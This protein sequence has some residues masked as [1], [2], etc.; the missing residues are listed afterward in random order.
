MGGDGAIPTTL[1]ALLE[2]YTVKRI[3]GATR[4]ETNLEAL[5][6]SIIFNKQLIIASGQGYADAICASMIA[7]PTMLVNKTIKPW[8][9]DYIKEQGFNKFYIFGGQAVVSTEIE[10]ELGKLGEVM[11]DAGTTRYETAAKVATHFYPD[12]TTAVIAS[13]KGYAD[14]LVAANVGD[15][16]ILFADPDNTKAARTYL[17][18]RNLSKV[19]VIGGTGAISDITVNW[20]L[21]K[22]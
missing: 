8:Q 7:R 9:L 1:E 12:A 4:Y 16:P 10:V 13:A 2:G 22:L 15:Y 14:G 6:E 5:K 18:T 20:A 3:A 17:S 11:R 19:Y 21:T